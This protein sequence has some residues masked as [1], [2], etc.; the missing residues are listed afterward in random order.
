MSF[1]RLVKFERVDFL[2]LYMMAG[3]SFNTTM[4]VGY[5]VYIISVGIVTLL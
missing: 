3:I 5:S 1:V 2:V 4:L